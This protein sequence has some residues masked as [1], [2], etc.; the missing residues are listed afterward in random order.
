MDVHEF[1]QFEI[2]NL[3]GDFAIVACKDQVPEE[4]E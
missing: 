1:S 4:L 3:T 2:V